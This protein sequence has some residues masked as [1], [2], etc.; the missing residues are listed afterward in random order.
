MKKK[1]IKITIITVIAVFVIIVGLVFFEA[2]KVLQGGVTEGKIQ[3][4]IQKDK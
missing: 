4:T 3:G 2:H 1:W